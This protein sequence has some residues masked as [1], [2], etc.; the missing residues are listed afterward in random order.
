MLYNN[1]VTI[2]ACASR[3]F[4]DKEKVV[5]VAAFLRKEGYDVV[6]EPDLCEKVRER[7]SDL[8]DIAS[9]TII[10]C[11]PRAIRSLF[12]SV[13]METSRV[14]DLRNEG[15]EAILDSFGFAYEV[16]P[17]EMEEEE[18]IRQSVSSFPVKIGVD[19]WYPT[20]D[21]ERC[22]D[23]GKC[24]DFCLFGVYTCLL[25]TSPSPRD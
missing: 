4:I 9:S 17:V 15:M 10:A 18:V 12:A 23:C 16:C 13:G 20:L 14:L 5:K 24:H 7:T 6:V 1:R 19:A 8:P 22:T 25:Y 11:Y 21:K 2:C 3:S